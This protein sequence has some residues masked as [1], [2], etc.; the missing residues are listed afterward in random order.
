MLNVSSILK[1]LTL[2]IKPCLGVY[3]VDMTAAIKIQGLSKRYGKSPVFAL[4]DLNLQIRPGEI[5]GFLGPNGAGKSTTIR[6]LMNFIQPTAGKANIL[7]F[8]IVRDSVAVKGRIGYLAGEIALYPHLTGRQLFDYLTA[9]QPLKHRDYLP[10]LIK[11]FAAEIDKPI[12]TLSKGNRQKLG[13]IQA[14][15]HEPE[16]LIMD[17]PTSGLDPLMQA[18]FYDLIETVKQQGVTVF[19]SSHDLTE[20]RKMCDRIGFIRGGELV[21]EKTLADLQASAAHSFDITFKGEVPLSELKKLPSSEVKS[22]TKQIVNIQLQG[23]L[24]PLFVILAQSAVIA[25]DKHDVN[26]EEEFLRLY[27]GKEPRP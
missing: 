7:G 26:L 3:T 2:K 24:K 19:L 20:V 1:L 21:A 23:D 25:L 22:L 17:E 9:L 11:Q 13:L 5:Y 6:L 10:R 27:D 12:E 14:L 8:D 18:A 4:K 16:L 15:M